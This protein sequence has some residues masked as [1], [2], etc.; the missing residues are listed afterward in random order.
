MLLRRWHCRL[1]GHSPL[2]SK[3]VIFH[4][5]PVFEYNVVEEFTEL[6]SLLANRH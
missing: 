6:D 3:E 5:V 2:G 1:E 4:S